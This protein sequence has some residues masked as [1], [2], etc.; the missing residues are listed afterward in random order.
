M[1][2]LSDRI[3]L[4][5]LRI[6]RDDT[7]LLSPQEYLICRQMV[8]AIPCSWRSQSRPLARS[9]PHGEAFPIIR[10]KKL[11]SEEGSLDDRPGLRQAAPQIES[12]T[13]HNFAR[14]SVSA[15]ATI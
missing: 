1:A 4:R 3:A 13:L 12:V 2:G 9:V 15:A 10:S 14:P 6:L 11:R 7:S 5:L 8:M